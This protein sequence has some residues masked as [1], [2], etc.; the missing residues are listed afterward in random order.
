MGKNPPYPY[1]TDI[2]LV[3]VK[4]HKEDCAWLEKVYGPTWVSRLEQHIR[5][6]VTLR[7]HDEEVLKV[8]KPWDY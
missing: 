8:K 5:S 3:T 2:R 7:K 1:G 6:E 4:M